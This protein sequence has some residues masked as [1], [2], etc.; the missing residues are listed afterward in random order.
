MK[1]IDILTVDINPKS[2]KSL[3]RYV[4]DRLG[5]KLIEITV[6][7]NGREIKVEASSREG[8]ESAIKAAQ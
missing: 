8:L 1:F 7:A 3:L 4:K 6:E 5:E 2:I